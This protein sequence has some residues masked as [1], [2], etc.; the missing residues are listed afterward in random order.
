MNLKGTRIK[1]SSGSKPLWRH[2][3]KRQENEEVIVLEG[4]EQD[5]RDAMKDAYREG[6][7]YGLR[8]LAIS[9]AEDE[10]MTGNQAKGVARAYAKEIGADPESITLVEH[11]KPRN[12]G[13]YERHWHAV[14]PEWNPVTQRVASNRK[15][16]AVHELIARRMELAFGQEP[17]RGRHNRA[18]YHELVRRG[19][20]A[21]AEQI[22]HLTEGAPANSSYG[23]KQQQKTKRLGH[24]MAEIRQVVADAW[25]QSDSRDAFEA[26]L[27]DH[28]LAIEQGRKAPWI[29]VDADAGTE[30]GALDRL[31]KV[32]RRDV[33]AR[34]EPQYDEEPE[35]TKERVDDRADERER[36]PTEARSER[37]VGEADPG[38]GGSPG[39]PDPEAGARAGRRGGERSD[40]GDRDDP[41]H[42]GASGADGSGHQQPASGPER[43]EWREKL[44]RAFRAFKLRRRARLRKS[45]DVDDE[46]DPG[47]PTP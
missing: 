5:L 23:G 9:P 15:M 26:A 21:E 11:K 2:L 7:R 33:R 30:F 8:H 45:F 19:F 41:G 12:Q 47:G 17:R 46:P 35:A 38:S 10:P 44:K 20:D 42:A 37:P 25:S 34:L 6:I 4:C 18:V 13:G 22:R 32:K 27:S 1:T 43:E 3:N 16:Y 39:V 31:A 36:S 40:P 28:G 14:L 29:V 24:N